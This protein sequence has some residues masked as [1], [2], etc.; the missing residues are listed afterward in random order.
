MI[1][2]PYDDL[3][4]RNSI[5]MLWPR[6]DTFTWN[7]IVNDF[8]NTIS[9]NIALLQKLGI[10]RNRG[11]VQAGGHC[12]L[13]PFL[14][15]EFFDMVF[16]FEPSSMGFHCLVNNCQGEN[17]IKMNVALGKNPGRVKS[18]SIDPSNTGMNRVKDSVDEKYYV[19]MIALDSLALSDIGL[20]EFDLEGYEYD[21]LQGARETIRRNKPVIIVENAT[22]DIEQFLSEF[23]YV[24]WKKINRLDS[25]FVL[26]SDME[27]LNDSQ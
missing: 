5:D 21:A 16:T 9:P 4:D 20:I 6:G 11:V 22:D 15:T 1:K 13:Y 12:G 3:V 2:R 7:I 27:K 14:F 25:L 17:V 24:V 18:F 26:E 10:I 19:P 23:G 8:V